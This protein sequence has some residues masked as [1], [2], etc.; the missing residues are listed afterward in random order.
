MMDPRWII[1]GAVLVC[2]LVIGFAVHQD[3]VHQEFLREH[4]CQ[5]YFHS[6]TGKQW[7]SGKVMHYETVT[8]YDCIGHKKRVE[9]D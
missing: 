8:I 9:I 3:N 7:M 1:G 6:K 5:Q 2:A 4:G